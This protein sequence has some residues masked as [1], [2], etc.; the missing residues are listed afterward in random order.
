MPLNFKQKILGKIEGLKVGDNFVNKNLFNSIQLNK[1]NSLDF[2]LD[3]F[4]VLFGS[5][6]MKNDFINFLLNE[7]VILLGEILEI[8]KKKILEY[9]I[10][11][12]DSK[13]PNIYFSEQKIK[14]KDI[15]FFGLL[16]I[17]PNSDIGKYYYP[18]ITTS[19][20]AILYKA[21]SQPN[22][23]QNWENIF[24]IRYVN[25]FFY[26]KI[27][28]SLQGESINTFVNLFFSKVVLF[29]D[30][31]IISDIID[32]VFN[33][34]NGLKI[35]SKNNIENKIKLDIFLDKVYESFEFDDTYFE[36]DIE[37]LNSQ[38]E[39]KNNGTY[40]FEGCSENIVKYDINLLSNFINDINSSVE[41]QIIY[42]VNF[43]I[44]VNST[45]ES[46]NNTDKEFFKKNIFVIFY[47]NIIKSVVVSLFSPQKILFLKIFAKMTNNVDLNGEFEAFLKSQ[48]NLV[49]DLIKEKILSFILNYLYGI[50]IEELSTLVANNFNK[51]Q[52]ERFN[53]YR[54]AI[55]SLI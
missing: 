43:N 21:I 32:S 23:S 9:Y 20:D 51:K 37:S 50:L 40:K 35:L 45:S 55:Q 27:D 2:L 15:D 44:L 26:V 33:T 30:I 34:L 19:L 16:K 18:N 22:I 49:K 47:R 41:K 12:L 17:N 6:K 25:E 39:A 29:N 11:N 10:C 54:L 5:A 38:Y 36:F 8:Y 3:I 42:D 31:S 7:L 1:D 53:Y 28:D 24:N 46:V 48:Q 14:V 52:K 4:K 13:I